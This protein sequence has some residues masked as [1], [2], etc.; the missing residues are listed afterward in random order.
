LVRLLIVVSLLITVTYGECRAQY[1][2]DF[3]TMSIE[4]ASGSPNDTVAVIFD[5]ANSVTVGGFLIRVEYD[6]TA[7]SALDMQL[8][9]R[10]QVFNLSGA[11]LDQPGIAAFYATSWDPIHNFIPA[12]R[13]EIAVLRLIIIPSA[14]AGEYTIGFRDTDTTSHENALSNIM[15]DSL[16][17]PILVD[18]QIEVLPGSGIEDDASIPSGFSLAQNYPNPFN[19]VTRISFTLDKPQVVD[20]TIFDL[21]GRPVAT[22]FSGRAQAGE[23]VIYWDTQ[24]AGLNLASGSYFYRLRGSQCGALTKMMT[25]LK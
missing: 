14:S 22:V 15:G 8:G 25:L 10:A 3:D 5:L 16:I 23:N 2:S 24:K 12:G 18:G 1:Y 13:G 21:L 19:G 17:I 20:V 4:G 7:F 6:D 9:P 11:F